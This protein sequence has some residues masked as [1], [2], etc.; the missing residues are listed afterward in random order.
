MY[1]NPLF[2]L[3]TIHISIGEAPTAEPHPQIRDYRKKECARD[4]I[5]NSI[6]ALLISLTN[7]ASSYRR[8][9]YVIDSQHVVDEFRIVVRKRLMMRHGSFAWAWASKC[10]IL[11]GLA[12]LIYTFK[13][14][15]IPHF[16]LSGPLA[17]GAIGFSVCFRQIH[18]C[19]KWCTNRHLLYTNNIYENIITERFRCIIL[20]GANEVALDFN[21]QL[22]RKQIM[23][24]LLFPF[25]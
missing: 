1:P 25:T 10:V 2:A 23:I 15:L 13:F 18:R 5:T 19:V 14:Q 6:I 22:Q 24:L 7:F 8:E 12:Q 11:F 21:C 20:D 3:F 17:L 9:P 16:S 4:H